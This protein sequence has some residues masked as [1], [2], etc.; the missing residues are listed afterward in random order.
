[1][2]KRV[3]L[4]SLLGFFA[5]PLFSAQVLDVRHDHD[6]WGSC[7]G[8]I[9]IDDE[10]IRYEANKPEHSREWTWLDIQGFDRR[11]PDRFSVLT[12]EDLRW[13]LGL[14]RHFNFTVLP[15]QSGLDESTFQIVVERLA[16]PATDRIPRPLEAEYEVAVKHLHLFGGC[17]GTLKFGP[18]WIVYATKHEEDARSWRRDQIANVW[19][20][21]SFELELRILEENRRA[22]DKATRFTFQLKEQI[23]LTYYE[24]LRRKFLL[25]R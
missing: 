3:L 18:E 4:L 10:G 8:Q 20:S 22:F 13:H 23:D 16:R 15:G 12:Y 2:I 21:N 17:E 11:S 14:D 9:R 5:A 6:P 7:Q 1:M 24:T 19:S 25:A